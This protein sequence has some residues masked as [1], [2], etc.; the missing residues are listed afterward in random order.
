MTRYSA[1]I[2]LINAQIDKNIRDRKLNV[3]LEWQL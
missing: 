1:K 3:Y 2:K